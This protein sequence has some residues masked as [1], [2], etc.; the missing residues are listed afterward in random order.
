L[1][2][3]DLIGGLAIACYPPG[4]GISAAVY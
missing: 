2:A 3:A 1:I 4:A